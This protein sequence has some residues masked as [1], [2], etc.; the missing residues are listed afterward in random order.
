[1]PRISEFFGISIYIYYRDHEPPHFHAIYGSDQ[2]AIRVA[3]GEILAGVL[4][5]RALAMVREWST[6]HAHALA[7]NWRRARRGLPLLP[8]P[9]L[10]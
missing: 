7:R 9:P 2:A 1:M 10:E 8:V 6:L 4:P 3:D 5:R